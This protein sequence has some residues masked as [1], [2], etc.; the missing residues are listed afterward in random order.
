MR[1]I[2]I[3]AIVACLLAYTLRHPVVG[4]YSWVWLGLMNPH[5][6]AYGFARTLPFAQGVALVT[7]LSM[8]IN[9]RDRHPLPINSI[10]ILLMLLMGWMTLTSFFAINTSD[11]VF[12]RWLYV[13]KIQLMLFVTLVLVRGRQQIERLILVMAFSV[14]FYGVKGGIWTVMTGGG[15]RVW[16]PSGGL[17][18][19]NNE[20]A[21]ALV[22]LVPLMFY[23]FQVLKARGARRAMAF[24][25]A[26]VAFS[27]LGSQSRGALLAVL[28]MAF[29]LGLKSQHPVRV[30]MIIGVV[31]TFALA[32]MPSSWT[33]RMDTIQSYQAD[34]SAMSRLYA[35]K[36]LWACAVDRPLVGAGFRAD[37]PEVY[38]R[39]A[40]QGPEYAGFENAFFVAHSIYLQILGEHGFPGMLLFLLIG[41]AT[42]RTAGRLRRLCTNDPEFGTWVPLLM[43]MVQVSLVGY[44]VGGAFLSLAYFD[45]PYYIVSLVVLV[46]AT[47]SERLKSRASTLVWLPPSPTAD[48]SSAVAL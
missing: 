31:V 34:S 48:K 28:A 47:V 42:W 36:T 17:V 22:M 2:L 5:R 25:M 4:A 15:G 9:R 29:L 33:E 46:D 43:P 24:S 7:L 37:V 30:S 8:L 39:Y 1:D 32:F 16:G 10:T 21:V 6:L 26:C 41:V 23:T 40:P 45:L 14:G 44:A 13:F 38:F 11:L 3:T 18:E 35:W 19:G 20:L 12:E 27:I